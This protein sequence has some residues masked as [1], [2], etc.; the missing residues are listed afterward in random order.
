[1]NDAGVPLWGRSRRSLGG[2]IRVKINAPQYRKEW[3]QRGA[4]SV[5]TGLFFVVGGF[6][7]MLKRM[8]LLLFSLSLLGQASAQELLG[9]RASF[10]EFVDDTGNH[11]G[12][13]ERAA[14]V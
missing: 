5:L 13:E 7:K 12:H 10:F 1:M 6:I 8:L 2:K 4:Q 3:G 9:E 14:R 11:I